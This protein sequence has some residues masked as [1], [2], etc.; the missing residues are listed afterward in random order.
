IPENFNAV[1]RGGEPGRDVN[2][3]REIGQLLEVG[4]W[5]LEVR[6]EK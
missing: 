5:K 2:L 4:S 3:G 1:G 6:S